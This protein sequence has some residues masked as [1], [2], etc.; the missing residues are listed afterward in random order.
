MPRQSCNSTHNSL[1]YRILRA[2]ALHF[3]S[4]LE[5]ARAQLL[6]ELAHMSWPPSM[7]H[8]RAVGEYDELLTLK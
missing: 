5:G 8:D 6:G 2:S 3:A 7:D 1:T 4:T